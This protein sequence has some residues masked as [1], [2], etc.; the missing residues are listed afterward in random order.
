MGS[1][2]ILLIIWVVMG[3]VVGYFAANIFKG[4]RPYGL[5]GD[6]VAGVIT[7]VVVGLGDWYLV[8]L[9]LPNITRLFLFLAALVEPF[10]GVLLVLWLMRYFK[11]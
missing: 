7:A 4:G 11:K 2:I 6:L 8:P 9:I 3:L 10:L 5:N 1:F